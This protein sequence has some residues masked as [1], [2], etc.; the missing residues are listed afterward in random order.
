MDCFTKC[1]SSSYFSLFAL[2]WRSQHSSYPT[3]FSTPIHCN[4]HDKPKK[5]RSPGYCVCVI[6]DNNWVQKNFLSIWACSQT[7]WGPFIGQVLLSVAPKC[8]ATISKTDWKRIFHPAIECQIWSA[9]LYCSV[10]VS[11]DLL[12]CWPSLGKL[13]FESTV[14]YNDPCKS[15][16]IYLSSP[17]WSEVLFGWR[18]KLKFLIMSSTM[19]ALQRTTRRGLYFLMSYMLESVAYEYMDASNRSRQS[20][21]ID[22]VWGSQRDAPF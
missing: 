2:S 18:R 15:L 17:T 8:M 22:M 13:S 19:V 10:T 5:D 16:I 4:M 1:F 11:I 14:I 21:G 7:Q 6:I 20:D 9:L 12:L 3:E